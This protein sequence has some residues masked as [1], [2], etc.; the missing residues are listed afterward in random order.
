MCGPRSN[1]FSIY[2]SLLDYPSVWLSL[3]YSTWLAL[4]DLDYLARVRIRSH[5]DYVAAAAVLPGWVRREQ[6]HRKDV[7]NF[8]K[9]FTSEKLDLTPTDK[10]FMMNLDQNEFFGFSFLNPEFVQHVWGLCPRE[11]C[12]G[13][14]S[15]KPGK[16]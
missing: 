3:Y 16:R 13:K 11:K 9:Q 12:R 6:K 1:S 15:S 7:S 10:L 2:L 8:D 4:Y 5:R 14:T